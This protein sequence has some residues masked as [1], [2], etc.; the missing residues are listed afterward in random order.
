MKTRKSK[1]NKNKSSGTR[2]IKNEQR[3]TLCFGVIHIPQKITCANQIFGGM[4]REKMLQGTKAKS[5]MDVKTK[6]HGDN[7]F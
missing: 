4:A 2:T 3:K 7:V 1:K 6:H 5:N